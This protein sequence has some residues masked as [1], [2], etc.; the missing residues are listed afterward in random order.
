[1]R[2]ASFVLPL[3]LC[4]VTLLPAQQAKISAGTPASDFAGANLCPGH[5]WARE[6]ARPETQWTRS[7]ED[8]SGP[9]FAPAPGSTGLHVALS[10]APRDL[11]EMDLAVFF[12]PPG[13][14]LLGVRGLSGE[15]IPEQKKTFR[16][17]ATTNA[18]RSLDGDLLVGPSFEIQRVHLLSV[19]YKDGSV[20]RAASESVCSIVPDRL[21]PVAQ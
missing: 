20:W 17:V 21:L 2:L 14:R 10:A 13:A 3:A 1:M 5:L 11:R 18:A 16:L 15:Q 12:V 4:G 7:L 19:T 8:K 6:G 9:G